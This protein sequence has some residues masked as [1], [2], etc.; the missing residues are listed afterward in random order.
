MNWFLSILWNRILCFSMKNYWI[1]AIVAICEW[2]QN[3]RS[4]DNDNTQCQK[5]HKLYFVCTSTEIYATISSLSHICNLFVLSAENCSTYRNVDS[6]LEKVCFVWM[7][8]AI[9][10]EIILNGSDFP[11]GHKFQRLLLLAP[12]EASPSPF[13]L[14]LCRIHFT[15][16]R[17]LFQAI[18]DLLKL[19]RST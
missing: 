19:M 14:N 15:I 9:S 12:L 8:D 13:S 16:C 6:K 3:S 18:G 5:I 4:D 11:A 10:W 17:T 1:I 7:C 2:F